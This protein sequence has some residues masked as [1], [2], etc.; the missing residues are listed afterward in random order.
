MYHSE[1]KEPVCKEDAAVDISPAAAAAEDGNR[2]GKVGKKFVA[3]DPG[4]SMKK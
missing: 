2:R 1:K 3:E 4:R